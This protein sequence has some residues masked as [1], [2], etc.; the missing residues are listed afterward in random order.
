MKD[1]VALGIP[2]IESVPVETYSSHLALAADMGEIVEVKIIVSE[3][4]MPHDRARIQIFDRAIEE[5]CRYLMFVDDDNFIPRGSFKL[6]FDVMVERSPVVVSGHYLRRGYPYTS[7][8]SVYRGDNTF[9]VD[10]QEGVHEINC[11]G[12]GCA[13][14]D[15]GWVKEHLDKPYFYMEQNQEGTQITDD[16]TFFR[17]IREKGG[18]VLGHGSVQCGHVGRRVMVARNSAGDLRH[19]DINRIVKRDEEI[20][21]GVDEQHVE[22]K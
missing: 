22:S 10:A 12:L 2:V 14:I 9:Q 8:W 11:S 16:V 18:L 17:Q 19:F 1:R 15:V 13:L 20:N 21:D 5:E 7:V 6:L 3:S 4:V